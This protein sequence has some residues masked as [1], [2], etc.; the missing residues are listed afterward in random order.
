MFLSA[1]QVRYG[2]AKGVLALSNDP[3]EVNTI[4]IRKSMLKFAITNK[5]DELEIDILDRNKY[6]AGFLNRQIIIL[7][8]SL[9][10]A[11]ELFISA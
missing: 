6:R 7:L 3:N 9:K 2:G 8:S 1:I 10:I 5:K 11:D 4:K